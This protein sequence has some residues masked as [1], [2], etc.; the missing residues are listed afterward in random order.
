MAHNEARGSA[1]REGQIAVFTGALFGATHTISGHAFDNWK[2]ACQ[3]DSR[4]SA[5]RYARNPFLVVPE[6]WQRDGLRAFTRGFAPPL[7][8]SSIYRSVMISS[9]EASY[10]CF[11]SVDPRTNLGAFLQAEVWGARLYVVL[12]TLVCSCCRIVV[13]SPIEYAKVMG[14]TSQP[15]VAR[16]IYRGGAFQTART[17]CMM[18]MIFV[19]YDVI[20]RK[21]DWMESFS[22]Q[23]ACTMAVC[24]TSSA[25]PRPLRFLQEGRHDRES[26]RPPSARVRGRRRA[27]GTPSGGP[28]RP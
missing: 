24:S 12:A 13:E 22:G 26:C 20:R 17:C 19:P 7:W 27:T 25:R 15:W 3:L 28:S 1:L 5:A 4:F 2:A 6:M 16:D 23:F 21:T 10:T 18:C 11:D 9:Y 14:Q 8:G